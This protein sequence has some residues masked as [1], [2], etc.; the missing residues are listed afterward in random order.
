MEW[1]KFEKDDAVLTL[2]PGILVRESDIDGPDGIHAFFQKIFDIQIAPVGCVTTM[3]N[4]DADG[5]EISGTGG[6]HDFF[7]FVNTQDVPKLARKRLEFGMRWWEDVYFNEGEDISP[8]E[9]RQ[10][11]CAC[12]R[13]LLRC[14][15]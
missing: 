7:F 14:E 6:R 5:K 15:F 12:I 10:A 1:K 11:Y 9:F 4:S 8:I 13:I 2:W 3:P